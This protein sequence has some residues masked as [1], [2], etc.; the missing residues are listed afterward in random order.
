MNLYML[1]KSLLINI[2][3]ME[4]NNECPI[5]FCEIEDK[6]VTECGHSFCKKCIDAWHKYNDTCHTCKCPIVIT[7]TTDR[8]TSI[9]SIP[10]IIVDDFVPIKDDNILENGDDKI[11]IYAQTFNFLRIMDGSAGLCYSN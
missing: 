3:N 1:Y 5:C 4:N 6:Y 10:P 2:F 8:A 11:F 9:N 7:I